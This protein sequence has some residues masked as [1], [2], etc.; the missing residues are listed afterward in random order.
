MQAADYLQVGMLEEASF[1]VEAQH[2]AA[3]VGSGPCLS[4][5]GSL[6]V[7]ATPSLIAFMERLAHHML[8]KRLPV[9]LSSVGSRVQVN[10]LAPT[11]VGGR[12]RVQA[13]ISALEGRRVTLVLHAWDDHELV[14][15]G[16]HLRV[17]IEREGFA[18]RVQAKRS[19]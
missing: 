13:E 7:L 10:H 14:G 12:V 9:S 19:G 15:E 17:V 16:T 1:E 4:Q 2:T 5:D 11:P 18:R 8:E 3:Q 6:E